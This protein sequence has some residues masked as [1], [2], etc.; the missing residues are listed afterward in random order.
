VA[1]N[2]KIVKVTWGAVTH[3]ATY[4]AYQ[5]TTASSGPYTPVA[6]GLA[7]TTWTSGTLANGTY[8]YEVAAYVGTKWVSSDSAASVKRTISATSPNCA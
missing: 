7:T 6:T 8:W 1:S 3:A 5:S 4:T 2:Q